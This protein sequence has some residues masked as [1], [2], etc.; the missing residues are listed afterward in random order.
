M[1]ADPREDA[2]LDGHPKAAK[3]SIS[4][5]GRSPLPSTHPL[6]AVDVDGLRHDVIAFRARQENGASDQVLTLSHSPKRDPL[7]DTMVLVA[8]WEAFVLSKEGIDMIPMLAVDDAWSNGV[9]I[10][11]VLDQV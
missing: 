4:R 2:Y 8:F 11:P 6:P 9:H 5:V 3:T 7:A 1:A 10:D